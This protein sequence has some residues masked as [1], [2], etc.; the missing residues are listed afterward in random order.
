MSGSRINRGFRRRAELQ[1]SVEA[2][3]AERATRS[4]EQQLEVLDGRLGP[5]EGAVKERAKLALVIAQ[6]EEKSREKARLKSKRAER[7]K[8]KSKSKSSPS[9]RQRESPK[10]RSNSKP[11]TRKQAKARKQRERDSRDGRDRQ[12]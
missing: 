10:P 9:S 5:G 12:V 11:E 2:L 3:T 4:P 1:E 7:P 8:S 6:R